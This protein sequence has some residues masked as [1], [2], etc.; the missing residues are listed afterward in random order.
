M[1]SFWD[2]DYQALGLNKDVRN[3][4]LNSIPSSLSIRRAESL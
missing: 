4:E 3:A 2:A 1:I